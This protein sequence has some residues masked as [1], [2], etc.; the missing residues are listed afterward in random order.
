MA[1]KNRQPDFSHRVTADWQ[2]FDQVGRMLLDKTL[3]QMT[4]QAIARLIK[5]SFDTHEVDGSLS[6]DDAVDEMIYDFWDD[7]TEGH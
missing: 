3:E 4:K 2:A 6:D 5:D 7:T 1:E